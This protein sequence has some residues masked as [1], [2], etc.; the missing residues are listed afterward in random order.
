METGQANDNRTWGILLILLAAWGLLSR[1]VYKLVSLPSL[2]D[3]YAVLSLVSTILMELLF[4]PLFILLALRLRNPV[5][6]ILLIVVPL[7]LFILDTINA[8]NGFLQAE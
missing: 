8:V 6:K 4:F 1:I 5:L 7:I 3:F 2:H